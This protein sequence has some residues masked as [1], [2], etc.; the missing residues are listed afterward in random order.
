MPRRQLTRTRARTR[1][2][3]AAGAVALAHILWVLIRAALLPL[4]LFINLLRGLTH[5]PQPSRSST[6]ASGRAVRKEVDPA[7]RYG[8]PGTWMYKEANRWG[9]DPRLYED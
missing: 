1:S 8:K 3:Q 5:R 2:P 4:T 6:K 7:G 9:T